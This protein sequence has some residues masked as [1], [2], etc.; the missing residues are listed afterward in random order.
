MRL[1]TGDQET[2]GGQEMSTQTP[3]PEKIIYCF[4]R[5]S[6]KVFT[7]KSSEKK[8]RPKVDLVYKILRS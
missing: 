7:E 3:R 2:A 5:K 8:P 1:P 4:I 6:L